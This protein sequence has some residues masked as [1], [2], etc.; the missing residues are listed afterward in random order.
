MRLKFLLIVPLI[1]AFA[2]CGSP[3]AADGEYQFEIYATN[4][5]HGKVFDINY[6]DSLPLKYSLASAA[7]VVRSARERAGENRV[8]LIDNGDHLQGDNSVFYYNYIDTSSRHLF[9]E[10]VSFLRY[11]AVTVG[12][13]DIEAGHD[14]YDKLFK[15]QS[16]P[17]LAANAINLKKGKPYFEPYKII[18]RDGIRIAIIGMTNPNIKKWLSQDLWLGMDFEEIIPSLEKWVKIVRETE[19]PH[20][21]IAALHV[22]LGDTTVYEMENP[23]RYVAANVKGIDL[24]FAA[25]DHK[26][27]SE[28]VFNGEDSILVIEGGGRSSA[29][30]K[31]TANI[32]IENGKVVKGKFAG[33]T[34]QLDGIAPD[35]DYKAHFAPFY[36]A[37]RDFTIQKVGKLN[38]KISTRDAFFGPSAYIDM[39]HS[40][41]LKASGAQISFAA[42]LSFDVTIEPKDLNYQD[43]LNLYPFENQLFVIEL[44]G[45][46]ILRYLEFSYGRWVNTM[47][48]KTDDFLQLNHGGKGERGK[49]KNHFFNFDSAA[50]ILYEV[51]VRKPDGSKI[52]IIS[53]ADGTKFDLTAKY[54]VALS[55]YRAN[56]GGDHLEK[57]CG[58]SKSDLDKRVL[59]RYSDIREILYNQ[60]KSDGFI[61]AKPLNQWKFI[62]QDM[63]SQAIERDKKELF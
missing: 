30:S 3:K 20:I 10:I 23:A 27:T 53:M 57:G 39:I 9:S 54:S 7:S 19:K 1:A 4:D 38:D 43:L 60:I 62:P 13:H 25:H 21:V 45:E 49:F 24:V 15:H 18:E 34:I 63:I 61:N 31:V 32:T 12:N 51:D 17:Y 33:E 14:V 29:I 46:E 16:V 35:P 2:S 40:L 47:K 42:P 52:S 37:V 36:K 50:G 56:G 6:T 44:T 58:I 22:G 11:D 28:Y 55:S 59:N 8:L 26:T 5:I 41:Q 48:S